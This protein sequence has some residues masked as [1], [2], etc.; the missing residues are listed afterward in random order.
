MCLRGF[1]LFAFALAAADAEGDEGRAA[2]DQQGDDEKA[3]EYIQQAIASP[4]DGFTLG[5]VLDHAGDIALKLGK[6]A[7][8]L[9]LYRQARGDYLT[10]ELDRAALEKKI[11]ELE[12]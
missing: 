1:R 6:K 9:E 10:I 7:E 4:D 2:E 3:W 12:K 11:R 8:A 5:V